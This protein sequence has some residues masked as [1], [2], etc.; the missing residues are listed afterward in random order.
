MSDIPFA[1]D[2]T[3]DTSGCELF[4]AE[5]EIVGF[6]GGPGFSPGG[7]YGNNMSSILPR[8]G[9][10]LVY[11]TRRYWPDPSAAASTRTQLG[12]IEI[13]SLLE[14]PP[15]G[16]AFRPLVLR[17]LPEGIGAAQPCV[18]R[19]DGRYE[20]YFWVHGGGMVRYVR[21]A[22][23][24]GHTFTLENLDDPC[25]YHPADRDV[26]MGN[27]ADR[28]L[29]DATHV[30]REATTPRSVD[31]RKKALISNDATSVA[32]DAGSRSYQMYSVSTLPPD[33]SP[34]RRE[35]ALRASGFLRVVHRRASVDGLAWSEPEIVLAPDA[36]DPVDAQFYVA[37]QY[38]H[39]G[40][41]LLVAGYF[42]ARRQTMEL[43][44]AV[45]ADG[46]RIRRPRRPWELRKRLPGDWNVRMLMPGGMI[47][48]EGWLYFAANAFGYRHDELDR[49]P[50][51]EHRQENVLFRQRP[52]RWVGLRPAEET[53][54]LLSAP[55]RYAPLRLLADSPCDARVSLCSVF[56]ESLA[57]DG[58][59]GRVEADGRLHF[60]HCRDRDPLGKWVRLELR[61]HSPV[62]G[63]T[64]LAEEDR[65]DE[66]PPADRVPAAWALAAP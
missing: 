38:R 16:E 35:W 9:G 46:R 53:G 61:F 28:L 51:G 54:R 33:Y 48:H 27:Q 45:S 63:I 11:L 5:P 4:F 49:V 18:L 15:L 62:Y 41:N 40:A 37:Q 20:L 59:E 19:R 24:D 36:Q 3:V 52:E 8:Q 2:S 13:E 58:A 29:A 17:G 60:P 43:M 31:P 39:R 7:L 42:P 66:L 32:Y 12:V 65:H 56:G 23:V 26:R 44:P 10:W 34:S 64:F 6:V 25:L 55:F 22:G 21:A 1:L 30:N 57:G 14:W 50:V 47:E